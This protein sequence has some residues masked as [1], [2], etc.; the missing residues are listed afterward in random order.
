MNNDVFKI[1][2]PVLKNDIKSNQLRSVFEMTLGRG[3]HRLNFEK[4]IQS[5]RFF[6]TKINASELC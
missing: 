1:F 5:G 4:F 6:L 3:A 2:R